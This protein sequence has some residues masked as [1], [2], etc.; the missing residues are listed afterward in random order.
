MKAFYLL[1][2]IKH[3]QMQRVRRDEEIVITFRQL[4]K[5]GCGGLRR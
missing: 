4:P 1:R 2:F 5:A 3:E